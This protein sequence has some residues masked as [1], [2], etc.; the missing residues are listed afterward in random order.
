MA[1]PD[2][3]YGRVVPSLLQALNKDS[4]A[5][6]LIISCD[7]LGFCQAANAAIY[8]L[9]HAKLATSASLMVPAPWA[10]AAAA[11]YRG[12]DIGVHLTL[13]AELELYRYGPITQAPSLLDGDGGFPRTIADVWEHAD[14]DEVRREWR[15]QVERAILWGFRVSHLDAHLAGVE[16]KPEFFDVYLDL[17]DEYRLAV[18]L[19]ALEEER[20][21]GFPFRSLAAERGIIAPDKVFSLSSFGLDQTAVMTNLAALAPGVYELHLHPAYASEELLGADP[22]WQ[23]RVNELELLQ[24]LRAKE[25]PS[26]ITLA[27]YDLLSSL[28]RSPAR[29]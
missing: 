20:R 26:S 2:P 7:E 1:G 15:A 13:N 5:R 12:E 17:A 23:A 28:M 11:T 29:T 24:G 25:L 18:R 10:R 6:V 8:D 21:I 9:L 3:R 14:L 22:D 27:G 4:D 16:L 19:P